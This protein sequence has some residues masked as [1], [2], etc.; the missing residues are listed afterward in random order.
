MKKILLLIVLMLG[1]VGTMFGQNWTK[2]TAKDFK[3]S[4]SIAIV[5]DISQAMICDV[6]AE[7]FPLYY[8]SKTKGD[9]EGIKIMLEKFQ[10]KFKSEFGKLYKKNIL[11][12]NEADY[13]INY[14]FKNINE[15]GSFSG[16][17]YVDNKGNKSANVEFQ[18]FEG[19]W[20]DMET[21]LV[22]NIT[23]YFRLSVVK[24]PKRTQGPFNNISKLYKY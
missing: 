12:T 18:M 13:V 5:T 6:P 19:R 22:E 1:V 11:E 21:L 15:D 14:V 8:A 9:A 24:N 17:F 16:Y 20:N 3:R 4:K 2:E 10:Y 7:K 23:R